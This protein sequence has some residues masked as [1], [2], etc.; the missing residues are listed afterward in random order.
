M[1]LILHNTEQQIVCSL[2][3]NMRLTVDYQKSYTQHFIKEKI[4]FYNTCFR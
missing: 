3:R 2:Q 1:A 4:F